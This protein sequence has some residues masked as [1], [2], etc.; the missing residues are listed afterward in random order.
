[1]EAEPQPQGDIQAVVQIEIGQAFMHRLLN[2][3]KSLFS[4]GMPW[5][6]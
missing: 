2:K 3:E 5:D 1:M 4:S 6:I